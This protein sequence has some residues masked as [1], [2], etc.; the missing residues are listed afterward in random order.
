M[1]K[2]QPW[3]GKR[4]LIVDDSPNMLDDL[5]ALYTNSGMTIAGTAINGVE[6][7]EKA[8]IVQPDLVS[9]DIIMPEMNGIECCRHLQK[10]LPAIKILFISSLGGNPV[11]L[12]SLKAEFPAQMFLAKP[13]T[14]GTLEGRLAK[15]FED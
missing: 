4:V 11:F 15:I 9:L 13:V 1:S 3:L 12:E 8:A 6:A 10:A 7:L 14:L 5:K 2:V